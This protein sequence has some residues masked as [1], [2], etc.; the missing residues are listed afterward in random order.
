M[1]QIRFTDR[2]I[3]SLPRPAKGQVSYL[4]ASERGFGIRVGGTKTW[5]VKYVHHGRQRWVSLGQ[6]PAVTLVDARREALA[7]K[8]AVAKGRDPAAERKA[9]RK[10]QTE[11]LTFL[12]L[13]Q[14]FIEKHA[15]VK[16]RS[17]RDDERMLLKHCRPWHGRRA[18]EITQAD[19]VGL[20][21][22]IARR[23]PIAANRVLACVRKAF[24]YTIQNPILG[25]E[26]ITVNPAYMVAAPGQE[27]ERDRVYNE[28]ESRRLWRAF[29]ELGIAGAVFKVCFATGQR[30]N[31]VAGMEWAETDGDLWTLPGARTKNRRVHLMPLNDLALGVLEHVR[32]LDERYAFPST[33]RPG[34]A[35]SSFAKAARKVRELSGVGD[36][37]C[38]DLRRSASTGVTRLGFSR[39]VADRL[40]NHVDTGVGARYDRHSYAKEK[41]EA[42]EAWGR[43]LAGVVG[44][45]ETVVQ[46]VPRA[47]GD[48]APGGVN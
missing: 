40:L 33:V 4:D 32:G 16:K 6:Y 2:K 12:E 46:M 10:A 18:A 7:V 21:H 15:K 42:A 38:H 11:I 9:D 23:A 44:E 25:R 27:N 1:P 20:L 29:G 22:E 36:F 8:S 43:W 28:A 41:R 48:E 26:P 5:F 45:V 35:F 19:V 47:A 30:L 31:E 3:Q 17:W 37:R 24:N 14:H 34:Q 13:A 39:F